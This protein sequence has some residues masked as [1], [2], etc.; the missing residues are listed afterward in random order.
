MIL[1]TYISKILAIRHE[2]FRF[3][4]VGVIATIIHYGIY[5]GLLQLEVKTNIAYSLGYLLSFVLNYYLSISYTFKTNSSLK[6]SIGFGLSH[7]I[8]YL[9]HMFFLN[10]YIFIGFSNTLAPAPVYATVVPIN[11]ILIRTVLKSKRL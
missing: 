2:I 7:F 1:D 8:N 4:V 6:K 11:F 5:Y 9:L 3:A 10:L